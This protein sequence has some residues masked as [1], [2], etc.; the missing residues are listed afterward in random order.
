MTKEE[1]DRAT[2]Y[3][4]RR[5]TEDGVD[6]QDDFLV[7]HTVIEWMLENPLPIKDIYEAELDTKISEEI[8]ERIAALKVELAALEALEVTE[9]EGKA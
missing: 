7:A 4:M 9:L 2:E 6:I 8:A 3:V 5:M 1:L